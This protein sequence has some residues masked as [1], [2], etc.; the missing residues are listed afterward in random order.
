MNSYDMSMKPGIGPGSAA[1]IGATSGGLV[2]VADQLEAA[3]QDVRDAWAVFR[4]GPSENSGATPPTA[5]PEDRIAYTI[6]SVQNQIAM[7]RD[8]AASIR[9]RV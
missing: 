5:V 3:V 1:S 7:L 8:I 9:E 2:A 6:N 4:F